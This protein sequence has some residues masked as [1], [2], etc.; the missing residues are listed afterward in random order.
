VP[1]PTMSNHLLRKQPLPV[2]VPRSHS[3][4]A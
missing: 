2:V 1:I 4:L 3:M